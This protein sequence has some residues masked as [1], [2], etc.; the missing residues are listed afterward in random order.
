MG[1]SYLAG[2]ALLTPISVLGYVLH[3]PITVLSSAYVLLVGAGISSLG[4]RARA[5]VPLPSVR[6]LSAVVGVLLVA[7]VLISARVGSHGLG[8]AHYHVG[9]IRSLI[10]QGLQSWDPYVAPGRFD[11]AYHTNLYH[12]LLAAAAR[13]HGL[14]AFEVWAYA[15]PWTK[16]LC[17]LG[18]YR[19]A[20][21]AFGSHTFGL[22]AVVSSVAA[23]L[24]RTTLAYPNTLA[25]F[26]LV[27]LTPLSRS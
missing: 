5:F 22:I 15:L 24:A 14:D 11:S 25:A 26:A 1:P 2:C 10:D 20:R 12:A 6:W 23:S 21:V 8:D 4:S 9:R 3:W 13:L 18:A 7:D 17:A 27:P 16:V 19:L